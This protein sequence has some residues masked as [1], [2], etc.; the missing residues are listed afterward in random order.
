[1]PSR[2][3]AILDVPGHGRY[4]N[5]HAF[6]VVYA[7]SHQLVLKRTPRL[8][9]EP[10][11]KFVERL[12]KAGALRTEFTF[13]LVRERR[14]QR[15]SEVRRFRLH[16]R[17][18]PPQQQFRIEIHDPLLQ[19]ARQRRPRAPQPEQRPA[20]PPV[21]LLEDALRAVDQRQQL[22]FDQAGNV[23]GNHWWEQANVRVV[24]GQAPGEIEA[25]QYV[26]HD[27]RNA[28]P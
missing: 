11:H 20:V 15:G 8:E 13:K 24:W 14:G 3:R 22:V 27:N 19:R 4:V 28:R 12:L 26:F 17:P 21:D 23:A 2:V 1:M 7:L 18:R 9:G 25:V 6:N 10:T 5:Q 16:G